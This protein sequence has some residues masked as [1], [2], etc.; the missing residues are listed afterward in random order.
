MYKKSILMLSAFLLLA[1]GSTSYGIL[2]SSFEGSLEGW[3]T[4]E[5]IDGTVSQSTIGATVGSGSMLC[6]APGG[7]HSVGKVD[8]KSVREIL[9][10]PGTTI[11]LDVT[12]FAADMTGG[13]TEIILVI[14]AQGDDNNGANNNIGWVQLGNKAMDKSGDPQTITWSIPPDLAEKI[15]GS[16]DS[17]GWFEL[18]IVSNTEDAEGSVAKFYVDNVQVIEGS[19]PASSFQLFDFE[20][21]LDGWYTD[22]WTE[23]TV[24]QSTIGATSGTGSMLCEAPGGW[25][26]VAKADFKS[27]RGLLGTAGTKMALDVTSFAADMT[28]AWTEIILVINAQNND[29]NGANNN[30]GWNQSGVLPMDKTGVPQT[31]IWDIPADLT[32]KIAS[33]DDSIAWFEL[34]IVSNTEDAEGSVAKFYVDNIQIL[35][36]GLASM[37]NPQDGAVDVRRDPTLRWKSGMSAETHDIYIGADLDAVTNVTKDDLASYPEV[38]YQS[39]D[40]NSLYLDALELGQTYYWRIDEVNDASPDSPWVG[41]VWSFTVGDFIVIDDFEDYTNY[42]GFRIW[43]AW[44]DGWD[45]PLINGSTV[46]YPAPVFELG[47]SFH[48]TT[49]VRPN[50]TQ[51]MPIFYENNFKYS[52]ATMTLEGLNHDW[53]QEG[54]QQLSL[55][56]RGH[57]ISQ[58]SLIQAAG[59][60]TMTGAGADI[61]EQADQFHFAWKMLNGQGSIVAK[62]DAIT[63]DDLNEWAKAGIMIR[64]TLD[65]NSP[66]AFMCVTNT[67]GVAFQYRPTTAGDSTSV[68]QATISSRPQWLKLTK[69]LA[70]NFV[71][72]H[73]ND[74]GGA[75]G[76][77]TQVGTYNVQ[78]ASNVY[79]GL[80]VTSHQVYVP[81]QAVFSSI[82]TTG[83]VTGATFTNQDIGILS[84]APERMYVSIANTTGEPV[85]IYN[86]DPNAALVAEWTEWPILLNE[87][88]GIDLTDV[89]TMSIGFGTKGNASQPGGSGLVFFDDVRLYRPY[90]DLSKRSQALA[91]ADFAPVSSGGDCVVDY[92]ELEIV[93]RDWLASDA[94]LDAQNRA[95]NPAAYY[96]LNTGSGTIAVDASGNGHDALIIGDGVQW[97]ASQSAFGQALELPGAAPNYIEVGTWNPSEETGQLSIAVWA[98]WAGYNGGWQGVMGKRDTWG[99]GDGADM[100]W[101]LEIGRDSNQVSFARGGSNPGGDYLMQV[102]EWTH[103]AVTFDGITATVY[104]NGV[105][106][107][108]GDFSFGPKTDARLVIGAVEANGGNPFNGILDEV[109]IFDR[110]ILAAEVSHLAALAPGELYIPVTSPAELSSD[111]PEGERTV[112]F[113]DFAIVADSWLEE[114]VFLSSSN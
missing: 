2:L 51:S 31:I 109:Y 30:I 90:C 38:I 29:D 89:N 56:Y 18:L 22:E 69:D 1:A 23:G 49:V 37:P 34:L 96:P 97:I 55:W 60:Y 76:P 4:D 102:G 101:H 46:G 42:E 77:Y 68:Q 19:G 21:G 47:E 35:I 99:T 100:M 70:G 71:A 12:S 6:E 11:S 75:P 65:P 62:V 80:A 36:A 92:Q 111:E 59:T 81:A 98:N 39:S 20:G 41:E 91:L 15:A 26:S 106:N 24:S 72:F 28:G 16:D 66:H 104:I 63:G 7:W 27:I 57:P 17:I 32:A 5:W 78:M 61:W 53:T 93:A 87:F 79:I 3:Y 88:A 25:H 43:E 103:I 113:K 13:W 54:A 44:V 10:K 45:N 50:S 9:G 112:N 40:S 108:G 82:T 107:G 86:P 95:M 33:T 110:A 105:E 58:G 83:N 52:E 94:V 74:V 14:N 73:A 8:A 85:T 84:N 64:E 48:E 67:Q 114:E